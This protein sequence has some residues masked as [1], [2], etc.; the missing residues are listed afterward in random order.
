MSLGRRVNGEKCLSNKQH[1]PKEKL[2]RFMLRKRSERLFLFLMAIFPQALFPLVRCH[3]MSFV[4][5]SAW[6]VKVN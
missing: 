6:H 3:L 1:K 2:L 5:F 4:F